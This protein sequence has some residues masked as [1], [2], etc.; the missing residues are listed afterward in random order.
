V[1]G[2]IARDL[3]DLADL[4][5]RLQGNPPPPEPPQRPRHLAVGTAVIIQGSPYGD[6]IEGQ[7]G[8][9]IGPHLHGDYRV[10][11]PGHPTFTWF[12][13]SHQ[14][15]QAVPTSDQCL[16]AGCGSEASWLLMHTGC[17][18]QQDDT[19]DVACDQHLHMFIHTGDGCVPTTVL[20]I[21]Q[22]REAN[23][24]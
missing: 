8:Y 18:H 13:I 5:R 1:V 22:P 4:L 24:K 10:W 2:I 12:P 21:P 6:T 3:D 15:L 14:H 19:A 11:I 17:R 7:R 23:A 16:L 9:I 20:P